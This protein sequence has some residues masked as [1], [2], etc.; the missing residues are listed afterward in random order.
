MRSKLGCSSRL[1]RPRKGGAS[2]DPG[3]LCPWRLQ[4]PGAPSRTY[5]NTQTGTAD[6][7]IGKMELCG[8][9]LLYEANAT[10]SRAI[11]A[12]APPKEWV[13]WGGTMGVRTTPEIITFKPILFSIPAGQPLPPFNFSG[14]ISP[15]P[16]CA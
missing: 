14:T 10:T 9:M 5:P 15:D 11:T 13:G 16:T 8:K 12:Q 4:W 3:D 2:T 6:R 7:T 1:F